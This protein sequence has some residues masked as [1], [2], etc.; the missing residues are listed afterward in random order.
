MVSHCG[1][2]LRFPDK[3]CIL[4]LFNMLIWISSLMKRLFKTNTHF[5]PG[6]SVIFTDSWTFFTYSGNELFAG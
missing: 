6:L 1:L 5:F 3:E 2:N 4:A